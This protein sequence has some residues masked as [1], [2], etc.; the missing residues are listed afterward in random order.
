MPKVSSLLIPVLLCAIASAASAE[1]FYRGKTISIITSTGSGGAYD[2][3]AR[4][5]SRHLPRHLPGAPTIVVRNM[6]G[7][8]HTLATNYMFSTA[9][10]DGT[11]LATVNNS[12]P[13]HQVLDGRG[14]RFDVRKFGWVGSTGISNL[15]NAAWH[16][17]GITSMSQAFTR[18]IVT[19]AT[20]TGSGTYIYPNA[21][22]QLLGTKFKI[23]TGYAASPQIDLAME[24]G[25]VEARSGA[26]LAGYLSEHPDWI[27]HGKITIISQIG[28]AREKMLPDVP[29]IH[30]LARTAEQTRAL[31]LISSPVLVG[32]PYFTTPEVPADRLA[33]LR[34]AFAATMA[35]PAFLSEAA[36]LSLD[37]NPMGWEQLTQLVE[38]TVGTP[39]ELLARVKSMI[40]PAAG[41]G[42]GKS[43][44]KK[45]DE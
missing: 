36:S 5:I 27:K 40:E 41:D 22:N 19:G 3:M 18:Q 14:V 35:D 16:T 4:T 38:E 34:A 24:R 17:S 39:P 29:L 10:R 11:A 7:G 12:I 32:R 1:D 23:V 13:L 33:L 45:G 26:S 42:A 37:L 9:P 43:G 6:P 30:E 44:G 2:L 8:G 25:E 28:A 20:G 31:R 15:V 21:M